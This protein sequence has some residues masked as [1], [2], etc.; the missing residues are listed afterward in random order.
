MA[1]RIQLSD[2]LR[3]FLLDRSQLPP[4]ITVGRETYTL[5]S[6]AG[7]GFKGVV[8]KVANRFGRPR[9]LKLAVL[10]DYQE[11]SFLEEVQRALE[12][13]SYDEFTRLIDADLV[14]L[15]A[16]SGQRLR[17]VGFVEDW[18][19]GYTLD[20]FLKLPQSD[21]SSSFL[22]SYVEALTSA[23]SVLQ[24]NG[25]RHDDLHT[26]NVMIANP[27][28]GD[29]DGRHKI[30]IIDMGSLKP[31]DKPT[32]KPKDD[33]LRFVDH[34]VE[35]RNA[36]HSKRAMPIRERRFLSET[37]KLIDRMLEEDISVRLRDPLQIRQQF[38]L[39][40][41]RANAPRKASTNQL[42]SPFE[43][44]SAEH[45]ADDALLV[46]MFAKSCP[47]LEKAASAD[48]VLGNRTERLR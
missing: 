18:V 14:H 21:I 34:L 48:P 45:I 13:E 31:Y 25:L 19:D 22:V 4:E 40:I 16:P 43:F 46:E 1:D 33:H 37:D 41:S 10:E 26:G 35:I 15:D 38:Q 9:A 36:I 24:A 39:A 44:L 32:L 6:P 29:I 20:K 42:A 2:T 27:A 11:R 28:P 12:L 17:F 7:F 5:E 30:K 47:W 3:D 8:W 23:L